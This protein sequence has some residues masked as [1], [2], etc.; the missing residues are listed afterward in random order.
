MSTPWPPRP[1]IDSIRELVAN[2]DLEGFI[3]DGAPGDEYEIEA[4]LL[5]AAV[6]SLATPEL[7][8]S[9]LLPILE[10]IWRKSFSLDEAALE[11]RRAGL[12]GL[13]RQIAH[14]FGPEVLRQTS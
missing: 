12:G 3:A 11:K 5:F 7:T 13:A 6:A 14:F 8:S 4:E 9:N 2:A 1:D 10:E